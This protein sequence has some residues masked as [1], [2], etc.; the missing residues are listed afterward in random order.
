MSTRKWRISHPVSHTILIN[1]VASLRAEGNKLVFQRSLLWSSVID[2]LLHPCACRTQLSNDPTYFCC[3]T[4]HSDFNCCSSTLVE[5]SLAIK[6]CIVHLS[7][8]SP[9][10][11][12][13]S[14]TRS[15]LLSF[16]SWVRLLSARRLKPEEYTE[17]CTIAATDKICFCSCCWFCF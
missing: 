13:C 15:R 8:C 9:C 17:N 11:L 12:V 2:G 7:S 14:S 10:R 4:S 5:R 6:L 1:T 3:I 16:S